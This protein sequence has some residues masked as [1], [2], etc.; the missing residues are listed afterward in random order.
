MTVQHVDVLDHPPTP[1]EIEAAYRGMVHGTGPAS[2]S[3]AS[4]AALGRLSLPDSSA[5]RMQLVRVAV[6]ADADVPATLAALAQGGTLGHEFTKLLSSTLG[7]GL[8]PHQSG[9]AVGG[10]M[11]ARFADGRVFTLKVPEPDYALELEVQGFRQ[12]TLQQTA[13][14]RQDLLGAYF[15]LRA[16]E[17]LSGK[18]YLD[19]GFRHGATKTLPASQAQFDLDAAR[20]ETLLSGL[21]MFAAAAGGGDGEWLRQQQ[22]PRTATKQA[23][24][25]Q[26]LVEKCR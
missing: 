21:A 7:M 23:R 12:K 22:D 19:H 6:A 9:Q 18:V 5:L 11:A 2:L 20:Y 8:L 13:A 1:A 14:M 26:E 25:F 4:Q 24:A 16:L 3:G 17:P 10:T 15:R